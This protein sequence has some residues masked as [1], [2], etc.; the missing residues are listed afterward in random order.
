MDDSQLEHP[1]TIVL[2]HEGSAALLADC[3]DAIQRC[4]E[5]ESVREV[6]LL[7]VS[8]G[9]A[10]SGPWTFAISPVR[11][12]DVEQL[13]RDAGH[14]IVLFTRSE[15]HLRPKAIAAHRRAHLGPEV[16][17]GVGRAKYYTP[18]MT[19]DR[20]IFF[21][22]A[23]H[24]PLDLFCEPF[25]ANTSI[26]A[27]ALRRLRLDS[28]FSAGFEF[29]DLALRAPSA[30]VEPETVSG[31]VALAPVAPSAEQAARHQAAAARALDT[32]LHVW[33]DY[34]PPDRLRRRISLVRDLLPEYDSLRAELSGLERWQ[35][36]GLPAGGTEF[37]DDA[38]R[39]LALIA[40][41]RALV[42]ST[43]HRLPRDLSR[44]VRRDSLGAVRP[45]RFR[46]GSW[47]FRLS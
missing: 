7:D 5:V 29:V 36:P 30:L 42:R 4:D 13:A 27:D 37:V 25:P 32:F 40:S 19:D 23:I 14:G 18:A 43:G 28:T 17:I 11:I 45:G 22:P 10:P 34:F 39:R 31:A 26:P 3:L 15:V 12:L 16:R 9:P 35:V 46:P 20:A 2:R 47:N 41:V 8:M 24:D 6:V 38:S 1:T 21:R 44:P 33:P